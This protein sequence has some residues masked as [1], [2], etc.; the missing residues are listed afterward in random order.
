MNKLLEIFNKLILKES[1]SVNSIE[2]SIK[3]R[4]RVV[5][6][7]EGDP[8]HGIAPGIRTIEVYAYGLTKAGNPV[9]RAF[10]P[11]GD[12]A[13]KVPNWKFFRIDRIKSWKPTYSLVTKPANGFNPDGDRSMSVVYSIANFS[14]DI[15]ISNM[16]GPKQTPKVVGQLDNIEKILADRE[17]DKKNRQQQMSKAMTAKPKPEKLN[18]EPQIS[19]LTQNNG[20][21]IEEPKINGIEDIKKD[22]IKPEVI[23]NQNTEKPNVFKPEGELSQLDKIKDLNRRL[24]QARKIDLSSIPKK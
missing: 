12:T 15:D 6:N 11:Y 23:Q 18:T 22:S 16:T 3:N 8:S 21:T 20:Q 24:D 19:G 9:I 2:D 7:Y 5:I 13:S 4:Y 14:D 1:V 17:K 10:Q